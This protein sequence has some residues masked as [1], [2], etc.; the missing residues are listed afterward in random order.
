LGGAAEKVEL[1][2]TRIPAAFDAYLRGLGL[3]RITPSGQTATEGCHAPIDVFSAAIERDPN[4]ALA[5][6]GRALVRWDCALL[7]PN[8]LRQ[9]AVA[10]GVRVDA[11]RAIRLAPG[12]AD[13]YV[14]M[15]FLELG[16]K[17]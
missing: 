2:G 4:Y 7:S 16:A 14:A 11:E 1:G 5:Y 3:S 10:S 9:P 6:A 15:S 12:L 8:W 17:T 13:G